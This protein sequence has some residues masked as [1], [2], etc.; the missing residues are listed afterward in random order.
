[1]YSKACNAV[2]IK[3]KNTVKVKP[4]V[5]SSLSPLTIL[6]CAQ[7]TVAPELSKIAVFRS[8]TENGFNGS[9]PNGGQHTPISTAG[10]RLLWKKAQKNETKNNTSETINSKNPIFNPLTVALVWKPWYVDSLTTS[11]N[12]KKRQILMDTNPN[13]KIRIWL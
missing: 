1:M 2:N 8:G 3:P 7:V 11:L 13:N 10:E 6:W 9:I 12:H 4:L 5:A